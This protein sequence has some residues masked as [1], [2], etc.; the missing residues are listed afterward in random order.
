MWDMPLSARKPWAFLLAAVLLVLPRAALGG[1]KWQEAHETADDVHLT[2]DASGGA[3][4][5]RTIR[6]RV[7][8]G[9]FS[10]FDVPFVEADAVLVPEVE[11][12]SDSGVRYEGHV[13]RAEAPFAP[14]KGE[15]MPVAP[16]PGNTV[17]LHVTVDEPANGLR[18]GVYAFKLAY[19]I[20]LAAAKH[21][22]KDGPMWLVRWIAPPSPEG[23]DGARVTFTLPPAPT[24]PRVAAWP[25]DPTGATEGTVS[26]AIPGTGLPTLRREPDRDEI[27]IVRP[28]IARGEI[29]AWTI[30]VDPRA[31]A[32][33]RAPELAGARAVPPPS[34]VG[35]ELERTKDI[36]VLVAITLAA[37]LLHH[38]KRIEARALAASRGMRENPLVPRLATPWSFAAVLATTLAL[39]LVSLP[40]AAALAL[41]VAMAL[42][43]FRPPIAR[44]PRAAEGVK[45]L[46]WLP[47][48]EAEVLPE[49]PGRGSVLDANTRAG[50]AL[51]LALVLGVPGLFA[52]MGGR[53]VRPCCML[54]LAV[55]A[56]L[57]L[58]LTGTRGQLPFDPARLSPPLVEL[59]A[60]L[61]AIADTRVVALGGFAGDGGD[62]APVGV[63]LGVIARDVMPG[64][65]A[66]EIAQV[67]VAEPSGW[68]A[69]PELLVRVL[70][71]SDAE[72]RLRR[73]LPAVRGKP[74]R[75]P[76]EKVFHVVPEEGTVA[77]LAE[78]VG[79]VRQALDDRRS[80]GAA[81]ARAT[82][83]RRRGPPPVTTAV[84]ASAFLA[85]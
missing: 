42:A 79:R 80:L 37:G 33:V 69:R 13:A 81:P 7:V 65:R 41:V 61:A 62:A 38:R 50:K 16:P 5:E 73:A 40:W 26:G 12:M 27:E 70:E 8:A 68:Y 14:K 17:A 4:I 57:P 24:E 15:L 35:R 30:R 58:F 22:V 66:I 78:L 25:A 32:G 77:A 49:R 51:A 53:E 29:V 31:L 44:E 10:G 19:R 71:G 82:E 63:R 74:G 47:L 36:L 18:R 21:M 83:R 45:A 54:L 34:T 67:A 9:T 6:W 59:R 64:V 1:G 11:I 75:K 48:R 76:E 56:V 72:G 3:R 55:V 52:T 84:D 43:T 46:T 85:V 60:R 23:R 28:H 2:I 39:V 20:D